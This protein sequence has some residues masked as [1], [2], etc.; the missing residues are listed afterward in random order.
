MKSNE[1]CSRRRER[2]EVSDANAVRSAFSKRC[3]KFVASL[4]CYLIGAVLFLKFVYCFFPKNLLLIA[5]GTLW[6]AFGFFFLYTAFLSCVGLA[7]AVLPA[8]KWSCEPEGLQ[9]YLRLSSSISWQGIIASYKHYL[10]FS[11]RKIGKSFCSL[12][13]LV[14]TFKFLTILVFHPWDEATEWKRSFR[15]IL[16]KRWNEFVELRRELL[17]QFVSSKTKKEAKKLFAELLLSENLVVASELRAF[18]ARK[19]PKKIVR[20]LD[21]PAFEKNNLSSAG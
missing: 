9:T 12:D 7:F 20:I 19:S 13:L 10:K 21:F 16:K 2:T 5:S 6:V 15:A 3:S 14:V 11:Q 1:E 8:V 4:G 17:N 18:I